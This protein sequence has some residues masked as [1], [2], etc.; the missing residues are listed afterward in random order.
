MKRHEALA[1]LSREH[2]EA[3]ILA[4]LI[5]KNAPVYKGLPTT[6]TEKA[7]YALNVFTLSLQQHFSKEEAMLEIVKH[8]NGAIDIVSNEIIE[9]HTHLKAAFRL[10]VHSTNLE[11]DLDNL[12]QLLDKHI[13]KEERILF[14]LLQ[15]NC[16]EEMFQKIR[17]LF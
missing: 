2:H 1:P 14:P 4:Q 6:E 11:T 5:K 3:L 15:E 12:G 16:T 10:L 7:V 13:R 8:I 9:E 17:L